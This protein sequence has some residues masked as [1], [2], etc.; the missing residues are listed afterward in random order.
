VS[1]CNPR[2]PSPASL[3]TTAA[4]AVIMAATCGGPLLGIMSRIWDSL[5]TTWFVALSATILLAVSAAV[6][7][8]ARRRCTE[9]EYENRT[10]PPHTQDTRPHPAHRTVATTANEGS[11]HARPT[12]A[13]A[14]QNPAL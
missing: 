7:A 11:P 1:C 12:R 9:R 4:I 3:V 2:G 5:T 10:M 6:F 13:D 14:R 8:R